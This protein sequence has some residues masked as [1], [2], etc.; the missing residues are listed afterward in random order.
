MFLSFGVLGLFIAGTVL[1]SIVGWL[2]RQLKGLGG[3][4]LP[5]MVSL[6]ALPMLLEFEKEFMS[7]LVGILKWIPMFALLYWARPRCATSQRIASKAKAK[8]K[9]KTAM[10]LGSEG[11]E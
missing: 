5:V 7:L 3:F 1:G 8:A 2:Q 4:S 9:A 10:A 6:Y 11:I